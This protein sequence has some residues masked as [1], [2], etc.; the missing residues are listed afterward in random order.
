VAAVPSAAAVAAYTARIIAAAPAP[1]GTA[2]TSQSPIWAP[3]YIPPP[4]AHPSDLGL[5]RGSDPRNGR[6]G[7]EGGGGGGVNVSGQ[8]PAVARGLMTLMQLQVGE[9]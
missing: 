9:C 6:A 5:L 2:S 1:P 8:H 3:Q 7:G 4:P